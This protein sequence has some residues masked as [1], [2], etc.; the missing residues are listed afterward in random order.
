[1]FHNVL[2]KLAMN[3]RA[4]YFKAYIQDIHTSTYTQNRNPW[5]HTV[6]Q[7]ISNSEMQTIIIMR[8]K[9]YSFAKFKEIKKITHLA[10]TQMQTTQGMLNLY[11]R[12][13]ILLRIIKSDTAKCSFK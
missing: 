6:V 9:L 4:A 8:T 12:Y 7:K 13:K 10:V 3:I 2:R 11:A 1:M 5:R